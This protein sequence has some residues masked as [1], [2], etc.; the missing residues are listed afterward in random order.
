M[1]MMKGDGD[2]AHGKGATVTFC[3]EVV[4]TVETGSISIHTAK[5]IDPPPEI[6][7]GA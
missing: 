3:C 7:Q 5:M 4:T 6:L 2:D 1:V